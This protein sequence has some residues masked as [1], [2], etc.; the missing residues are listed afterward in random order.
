MNLKELTECIAN[1][2]EA[3][4]LEVAG[5]SLFS[6]GV[7]NGPIVVVFQ[8]P[9]YGN[10]ESI[11]VQRIPQAQEA[12]PAV[13]GSVGTSVL[14]ARAGILGSVDHALSLMHALLV[15]H[16]EGRTQAA[17]LEYVVSKGVSLD[18]ATFA[19]LTLCERRPDILCSRGLVSSQGNYFY[20]RAQ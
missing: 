18:T 9:V 8:H 15:Q 4:R 6:I 16:R 17:L 19:L 1:N 20:L 13:V 3:R 5:Y 7:T 12:P 10:K 14:G 11:Y 2:D